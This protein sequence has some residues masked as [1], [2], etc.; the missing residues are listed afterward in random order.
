MRLQCIFPV[1]SQLVQIETPRLPMYEH[2]KHPQRSG[3][4]VT[5]NSSC[6]TRRQTLRWLFELMLHRSSRPFQIRY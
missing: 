3:C 5:D 6:Q 1:L 2:G 4:Y